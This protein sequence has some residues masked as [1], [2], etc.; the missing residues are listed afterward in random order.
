MALTKGP[1]QPIAGAYGL[2][3]RVVAGPI[4]DRLRSVFCRCQR[5]RDQLP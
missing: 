2:P 1:R 4:N 5:P 3:A